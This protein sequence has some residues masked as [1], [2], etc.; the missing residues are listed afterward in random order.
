M[1]PA[2]ARRTSSEVRTTTESTALSAG[3]HEIRTHTDETGDH[4]MSELAR[5]ILP[6]AFM[7]SFVLLLAPFIAMAMYFA[8]DGDRLRVIEDELATE[9]APERV[10]PAAPRRAADELLISA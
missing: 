10:A 5:E 2:T 3:D 7:Y 4:A 9:A 1:L 8:F 6:I